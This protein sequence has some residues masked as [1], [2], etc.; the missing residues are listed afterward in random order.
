MWC[1]PAIGVSEWEGG[2]LFVPLHLMVSSM[3]S[4]WTEIRY[5][6]K[7]SLL[8]WIPWTDRKISSAFPLLHCP[9]LLR[10][11]PIPSLQSKGCSFIYTM[12]NDLSGHT[13]AL[14]CFAKYDFSGGSCH[15][16]F[17]LWTIMVLF[18]V[19]TKRKIKC[20]LQVISISWH[21][22]LA[23]FM[24]RTGLLFKDSKLPIIFKR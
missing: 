14:A 24:K 21:R 12:L 6:N 9:T 20:R 1:Y 11:N 19:G 10:R 16:A 18:G 2:C 17:P 22:W 7:R 3:C 13:Q 8:R 23:F 15:S 5:W 4:A